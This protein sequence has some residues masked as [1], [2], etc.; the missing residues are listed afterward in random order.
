MIQMIQIQLSQIQVWNARVHIFKCSF[1][2]LSSER[3]YFVTFL[4]YILKETN[5]MTFTIGR[6]IIDLTDHIYSSMLAIPSS[7]KN[8]YYFELKDLPF[9]SNLYTLTLGLTLSYSSETLLYIVILYQKC[10]SFLEKRK[11]VEK[12][13][14]KKYFSIHKTL[15]LS[16]TTFYFIY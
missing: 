14:I 6:V 13:I 1:L 4:S 3:W 15:Q 16:C 12:T 5:F 11:L 9:V 8:L 2:S 10:S 7:T